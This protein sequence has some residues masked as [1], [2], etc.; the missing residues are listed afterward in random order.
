VGGAASTGEKN[1]N[2]SKLQ[3]FKSLLV[4]VSDRIKEIQTADIFFEKTKVLGFFCGVALG[5]KQ[6]EAFV[7]VKKRKKKQ[8]QGIQPRPV[9]GNRLLGKTIFSFFFLL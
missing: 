9:C 2:A 5:T 8:T 1:E 3:W 7:G 6:Q 4:V